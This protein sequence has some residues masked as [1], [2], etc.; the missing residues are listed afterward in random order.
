LHPEID[1]AGT[2][3]ADANRGTP[4]FAT[5]K[6]EFRE[7]IANPKTLPDGALSTASAYEDETDE[8]FLRR[9]WRE[10]HGDEVPTISRG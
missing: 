9:V 3:R 4:L 1:D 10:L 2:L 6:K 5:F 7:V 8:A